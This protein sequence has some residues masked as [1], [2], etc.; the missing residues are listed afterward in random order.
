MNDDIPLNHVEISFAIR[1]LFETLHFDEPIIKSAEPRF[2]NLGLNNGAI[3]NFLLVMRHSLAGDMSGRCGGPE[4][5]AVA[6]CPWENQAV[7]LARNA[8][9]CDWLVQRGGKP[10]D[11]RCF[12][13]AGSAQ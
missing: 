11:I 1:L 13:L 2:R 3:E 5:E 8:E 9:L 12:V 6:D 4:S 10:A 7:F